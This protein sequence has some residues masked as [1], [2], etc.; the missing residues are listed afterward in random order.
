M[1]LYDGPITY[2][3]KEGFSMSMNTSISNQIDILQQKNELNGSN[4]TDIIC[5]ET[6][7]SNHYNI[8]FS[9]D[10]RL[11]KPY[12]LQRELQPKN[13]QNLREAI[14]RHNLLAQN[15]I[16]V[17][18]SDPDKLDYDHPYLI[19]NGNHRFT[20]AK[21]KDLEFSFMDVTVDFDPN[22][23]IDTGYCLSKWG[24]SQFLQFYVKQGVED[25]IKFDK[26]YK[27]LGLDIHTALPLTTEFSK[28]GRLGDR[29]RKGHFRFEDEEKRRKEL[30]LGKEFL[31]VLVAYGCATKDFL[32]NSAFFDGYIKLMNHPSF[33]HKKLIQGIESGGKDTS[34]RLPNFTYRHKFYEWFKY[35]LLKVNPEDES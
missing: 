31:S 14:D 13:L 24:I 12:H 8:Q 33:G 5:G 6:K 10:Y 19:T 23:L 30:Y 26:F 22:D 21:E 20:I 29:F 32:N 25:Y 7:S 35:N 18:R 11:F 1:E 34:L 2:I 4:S 17:I 9:K 15:P 27:E 3:N 16:Q 28:R